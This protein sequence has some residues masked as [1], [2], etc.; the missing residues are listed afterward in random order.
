MADN[1]T[2]IN[3][4]VLQKVQLSSGVEYE[5]MQTLGE[6]EIHIPVP[7]GT[8]GRDIN[9]VLEKKS[10]KVTLK[11]QEPLID[12]DLLKEIKLEESTWTLGRS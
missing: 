1:Q 3:P 11:Q 12:G 5:W 7:S 4:S 8:R 9:V 2:F 10:L 6:V